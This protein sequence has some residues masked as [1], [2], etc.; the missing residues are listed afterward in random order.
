MTAIRHLLMD[1]AG[2]VCQFDRQ[3]RLD[4]LAEASG[5][6]PESVERVIYHS[7]LGER[8]DRGEYTA[9]EIARALREE[10]DI[11]AP[12]A[13]LARLW[14]SAFTPDDSVLQV[15]DDVRPDIT[16]SLLTNNDA[17]LRDFMPLVLPSV[18]ARFSLPIFSSLTRALK[19]APAAYTEA[20]TLLGAAPH[21]AFFVDDSQSNVDG[22]RE[23]GITALLFTDVATLRD[24]LRAAQLLN[25][26]PLAG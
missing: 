3:V 26:D 24:D 4:N 8:F 25:A 12:D 10:L 6:S 17:L 15:V 19:P 21:D 22:A 1:L 23:V 2:V 11:D 7:G 16:R 14:A 13:D 5:A 9:A 20:L 18:H